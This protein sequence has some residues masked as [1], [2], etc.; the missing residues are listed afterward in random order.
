MK[1]LIYLCLMLVMVTSVIAQTKL[2]SMTRNYLMQQEDARFLNEQVS[3]FPTR[4]VAN[5]EMIPAFVCFHDG[6]DTYLLESYGVIVESEFTNVATALIPATTIEALSEE[7]SIRY[8][9][10]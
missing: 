5:Q 6:V 10:E 8:R 1:K 3:L 2:S 4:S 7:P 9:S